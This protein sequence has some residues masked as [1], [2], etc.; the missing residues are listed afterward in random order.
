MYMKNRYYLLFLVSMLL[1]LIVIN[2]VH[3]FNGMHEKII[4]YNFKNAGTSN[5]LSIE[6]DDRFMYIS[7]QDNYQLTYGILL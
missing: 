5:N 3:H 4:N 6:Y 1:L 7:I 2:G